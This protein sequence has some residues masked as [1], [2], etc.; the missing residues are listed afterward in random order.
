MDKIISVPDAQLID[1]V[2][3]INMN[4][5]TEQNEPELPDTGWEQFNEPEDFNNYVEEY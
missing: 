4:S 1:S 2:Q 3:L 5:Y